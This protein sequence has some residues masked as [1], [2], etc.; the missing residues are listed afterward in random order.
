MPILLNVYTEDGIETPLRQMVLET[1][2]EFLKVTNA[3]VSGF[4]PIC[5]RFNTANPV[6]A[7]IF[8]ENYRYHSKPF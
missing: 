7:V 6:D 2:K 8:F 3:Q 5:Y 1:V 4:L